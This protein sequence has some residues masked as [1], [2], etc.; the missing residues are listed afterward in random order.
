[1]WRQAKSMGSSVPQAEFAYNST[2]HSS[3]GMSPFSIIY[4]KVPHHLLDLAKLPI[5][6]KFS[7][8]ANAMAEQIIDVQKDVRT[9]LEKSNARYKTATDKRRRE[10]VF[11]EG[12]MI[13]AYL[14]KER[15]HV[16][17]TTS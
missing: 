11:E 15:I 14:R 12:D 1:V 10:K 16:G 7:S 4:R 2:I 3:M 5:G 13:V 9:R 8:T 6:E 17:P